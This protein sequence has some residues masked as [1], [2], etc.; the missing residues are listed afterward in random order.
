MPRKDG[1]TLDKKKDV[2]NAQKVP[3]TRFVPHVKD[4]EEWA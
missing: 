1:Y 4:T 3:H 2:I